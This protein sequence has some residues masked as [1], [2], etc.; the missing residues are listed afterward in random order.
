[1]NL[2]IL[3]KLSKNAMTILIDMQDGWLP[4]N[5]FPAKK[6]DSYIG[7]KIEPQRRRDA[8]ALKGTPMHAFTSYWG[9]DYSE[10]TAWELL[11]DVVWWANVD[12]RPR[13]E[14]GLPTLPLRQG[15]VLRTPA[16]YLR[17]ARRMAAVAIRD[18]RVS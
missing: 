17:E 12:D 2:R 15:I 7:V 18:R 8:W 9:D 11:R 13:G 6:E 16:D 4:E 14:D 10:A 1:M 3:K 5:F